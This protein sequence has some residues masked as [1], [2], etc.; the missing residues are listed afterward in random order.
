MR[1]GRGGDTSNV[2]WGGPSHW[3]KRVPTGI[4]RLSNEQWGFLLW[5]SWEI[6]ALLA[7]GIVR[8]NDEGEIT[9]TLAQV[10]A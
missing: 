4:N 3:S 7:R 6:F 8:A 10:D 1:P 5:K 2:L 9:A